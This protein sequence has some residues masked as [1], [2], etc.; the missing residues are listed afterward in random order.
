MT[1]PIR[2]SLKAQ[3]SATSLLFCALVLLSVSLPV[4]AADHFIPDGR[5]SQEYVNY[6][7]HYWWVQ[8]CA[9]ASAAMALSYGDNRYRNYGNLVCWYHLHPEG[10]WNDPTIPNNVSQLID[11]LADEMNTNSDGG[12]YVNNVHTGIESVANNGNTSSIRFTG[13]S[14]NSRQVKSSII[15][16]TEGWD[17]CWDL[18]KQE[19][20]SNRLFVWTVLSS[21]WIIFDQ[22]GHSLCAVGYTDDKR[23][24]VRDS[25]RSTLQYWQYNWWMYNPP[26]K[27]SKTQVDTIERGGGFSSGVKLTYP[28]GGQTFED[29]ESINVSWTQSGSGINSI[30]V[31]VSSV[32]S[33][34]K[35][36]IKTR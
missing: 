10:T 3:F 12:T 16:F 30:R 1:N 21:D 28:S 32:T 13:Y 34:F 7:D 24:I 33:S 31:Y 22:K 26:E 2:I 9:P 4:N 35:C 23:V 15:P 29:G 17:W 11:W 19:I 18:I 25:N 6:V 27:A 20:D 8:G 36:R 14:Y 5:S